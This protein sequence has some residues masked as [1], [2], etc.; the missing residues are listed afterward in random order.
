VGT[1]ARPHDHGTSSVTRDEMLS[2]VFDHIYPASRALCL[3]GT[4]P[5]V[6]AFFGLLP[7]GL[8]VNS[9]CG[10]SRSLFLIRPEVGLDKTCHLFAWFSPLG[11]ATS[12]FTRLFVAFVTRIGANRRKLVSDYLFLDSLLC[13]AYDLIKI[14]DIPD[15]EEGGRSFNADH[16]GRIV[17]LLSSLK[18]A[19]ADDRSKKWKHHVED[20]KRSELHLP[21][22]SHV[23]DAACAYFDLRM[24][25]LAESD[26]V[27]AQRRL[28]KLAEFT[29]TLSVFQL[30]LGDQSSDSA[31]ALRKQIR[32]EQRAK[33]PET[34]MRCDRC[35]LKADGTQKLRKCGRCRVGM[36]GCFT[37][38]AVLSRRSGRRKV[39]KRARNRRSRRGPRAHLLCGTIAAPK[40]PTILSHHLEL[41]KAISATAEIRTISLF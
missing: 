39:T 21:T 1:E 6:Q 16:L 17:N 35:D 40:P 27:A 25:G 30:D 32:D 10:P 23:H 20:P 38:P 28:I 14:P 26:D 22:L 18:D 33:R 19:S 7:D 36:T 2:K 8:D 31:G 34:E 9:A 5:I 15:S 24:P 37:N 3:L 29:H 11:V 41:P 13:L 4:D 12:T